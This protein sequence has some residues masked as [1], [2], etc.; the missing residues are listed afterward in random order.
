MVV[1]DV[2]SRS[3]CICRTETGKLLDGV[4]VSKLETVIPRSDPAYVM[5]VGGKRRGQVRRISL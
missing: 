1:I 3:E 4:S 2:I 5:V